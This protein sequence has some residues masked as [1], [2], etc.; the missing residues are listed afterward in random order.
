[1]LH[2]ASAANGSRRRC[3]EQALRTTASAGPHSPMDSY[4]PTDQIDDVREAWESLAQRDP[5]WAILSSPEKKG[6]EWNRTEFFQTGVAQIDQLMQTLQ[7]HEICVDTESVLDFGCGVGRLSQ[8]LLRH[9]DSVF[10]VDVA[11]TMIR[12]AQELN[13]DPARCFYFLNQQEDLKLFRDRQFCFIYSIIVLQ[14]LP[15]GLAY[16]YLAEFVRLLRPNGLLV[17]QLPS[18]FVQGE[19][20]LNDA[21]LAEV[22]CRDTPPVLSAGQTVRLRVEVENASPVPWNHCEPFLICLGNHWLS[23]DGKMKVRD[24]GRTR[25]PS[26]LLPRQKLAVE[27][28]ITAPEI[29]GIYLVE[30]DVVQE[31]ITWFKDVGSKTCTLEINVLDALKPHEQPMV[32]PTQVAPVE[33]ETPLSTPERHFEMHCTPRSEIVDYLYRLGCRLEFIEPSGLGGDSTFG[34]VYYVRKP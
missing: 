10:G 18:R 32:A 20:L 23:R 13:K 30:L 19:V 21:Y 9:F 24:D 33:G 4:A 7:Y 25:L 28:E 14:H 27:L 11:P 1:M 26:G 22:I 31:G 29:P 12:L 8:A 16:K 17:F 3:S 15:P 6:G 5:L 34:Y 2:G